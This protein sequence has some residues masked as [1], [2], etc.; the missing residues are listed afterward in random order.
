MSDD[1][2]TMTYEDM[3]E[4]I[5]C[6]VKDIERMHMSCQDIMMA[7]HARDR[8]GH[9]KLDIVDSLQKG[10]DQLKGLYEYL[11]SEEEIRNYAY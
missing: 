10:H 2:T 11:V 1:N 7:D 3:A 4:Q 8:L 9:I 6:L 5:D